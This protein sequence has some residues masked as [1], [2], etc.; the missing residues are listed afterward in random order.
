MIIL[1]SSVVVLN[2]LA[3][4]LVKKLSANS[5]LH[6]WVFTCAFQLFFDIF[7][8]VKYHGYWYGTQGI[9]WNVFPAY[10]ALIPPVNLLFLNFFPFGR[11]L[12]RRIVYIAAWEVGLLGYE[13]LALQ[14]D[15]WGYFHYGWWSIWHSA[16]I[17]PFLLLILTGYYKWILRLEARLIRQHT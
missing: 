5:A 7:I 2:S 3:Y 11:S 8:D 15:P 4:K 10:C 16:V 1:Y 12:L 14:P 13:L 6:I 17:N 9:D